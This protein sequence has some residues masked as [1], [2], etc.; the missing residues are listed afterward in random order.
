MSNI[1]IDPRIICQEFKYCKKFTE[2]SID[3]SLVHLKPH[4]RDVFNELKR[5]I[6]VSK[7]HDYDASQRKQYTFDLDQLKSKPV[8]VPQMINTNRTAQMKKKISGENGV[9]RF[10]Q[11]ADLH[12]DQQ[13]GEVIKRSSIFIHVTVNCFAQYIGVTL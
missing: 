5:T 3:E 11:L 9:L 13:Y 12:L 4:I 7:A 6:N 2:A 1:L 8:Q 10:L